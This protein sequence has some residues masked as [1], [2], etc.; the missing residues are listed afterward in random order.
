MDSPLCVCLSRKFFLFCLFISWLWLMLF[1]LNSSHLSYK[2]SIDRIFFFHYFIVGRYSFI[3]IVFFKWYLLLLCICWV[4]NWSI[5]M[6]GEKN[7]A[8]SKL[9]FGFVCRNDWCDN[10][11]MFLVFMFQKLHKKLIKYTSKYQYLM[12]LFLL[13]ARFCRFFFASFSFI[14]NLFIFFLFAGSYPIFVCIIVLMWFG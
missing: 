7:K 9:L 8:L 2:I 6:C 13:L 5:F 4:S 14:S 12:W 11:K 1:Y 3:A 10:I